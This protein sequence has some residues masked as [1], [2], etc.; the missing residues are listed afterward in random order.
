MTFREKHLWISIVSTV[1]I[2]GAY[3][4]RFGERVLEGGL[5]EA[6]FAWDMG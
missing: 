6:S 3:Y 1:V 2:W 4:W 5:R